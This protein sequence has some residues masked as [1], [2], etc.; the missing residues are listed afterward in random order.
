MHRECTLRFPIGIQPR[1]FELVA[2]ALQKLDYDGPVALSCDDT[3]L[4]PSLRPYFDKEKH[5]YFVMGN[6]G[7]PYQLPDPDAFEGV[8]TSSQLQKA[9]KV[10][11]VL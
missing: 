1:T 3:K 9:T 2:I 4:L 7:E 5:G 10:S 11:S 8:V 6:I